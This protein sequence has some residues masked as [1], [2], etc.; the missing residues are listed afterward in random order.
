MRWLDGI[1]DSIQ[2][3]VMDRGISSQPLQC[4]PSYWGFSDLVQGVSPH[5]QSSEAQPLLL[6]LDMEYLFTAAPAKRSQCSLP[7]TRAI[8][9]RL[10]LLTL[11][12]E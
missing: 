12:V 6:T 9:S 10:P 11:N 1:N 5:G 2:E 8:S 4:L 7:W 3:L